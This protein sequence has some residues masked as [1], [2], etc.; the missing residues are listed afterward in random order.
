MNASSKAKH[1]KRRWQAPFV[2]GLR[3]ARAQPIKQA[4]GD[5]HR[6]VQNARQTALACEFKN[7]ASK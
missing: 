7:P 2:S 3:Q 1:D 5:L 6:L 4:G